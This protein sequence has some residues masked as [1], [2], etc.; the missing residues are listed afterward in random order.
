M[1]AEQADKAQEYNEDV[2]NLLSFYL[3]IAIIT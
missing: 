2:S 3:I 1:Q